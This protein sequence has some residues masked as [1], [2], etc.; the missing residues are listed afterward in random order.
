MSRPLP[1]NL[2]LRELRHEWQA[3]AC[4]VGALIGV[5]AP[6][7]ILLALKN[8]V[9]G[10]M[11][12]RLVE[13]P[14][15]REI[16]AMGAKPYPPAFFDQ[17]AAREDVAFVVPSTRRIN[18]TATAVR[19]PVNRNLEQGVPLIPS[20]ASDPLIPGVAVTR[21]GVWI[22]Q[23]TADKLGVAPGAQIEM[24]IGRDIDGER[25][26]ARISLQVIGIVPRQNFPRQ[27]LFLSLDD[28]LAVEQFRDDV[29]ISP[30]AYGRARF[31][32]DTYA[33]FRMYARNLQD[34]GGLIAAFE[35]MGLQVRPRAENATLLLKFRDNLNWIYLFIAVIAVAGFWFSMAANLR[36]M[37]ERQRV[38][39]SL[40]HFA[41]LRPRQS[42]QVPVIQ[43]VI[44]VGLGV[45]VSLALVFPALIVLNA[46]F[47]TPTG[48]MVA[49]LGPLDIAG[50][51]VLG[52][53]VAA[54]AA[55]WAARAVWSI[56]CEEVLRHG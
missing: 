34:L 45:L 50:T 7:L 26:V 46:T 38:T 29:S 53:L 16:I 20:A 47:Q 1:I 8:G 41:G 18:A 31:T 43:S 4:F 25:E 56:P 39:F 14:A 12:D 42:A 37:V 33:S 36:G 44:L 24:L 9:I 23:A 54:T 10:A 35:G 52:V 17:M 32:P 51:L 13:D 49:A 3:A 2:A 11:V 19:N 22:S 55:L 40:L 15:N 27:A 28:L 6:L 30:D 21:G 48:D 5:L